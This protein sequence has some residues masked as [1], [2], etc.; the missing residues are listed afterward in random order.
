M[1]T[2]Q[3]ALI[4]RIQSQVSGFKTIGNP[5]VMAGLGQIGPLLPACLVV[6]GKA[7]P[8]VKAADALPAQ[9]E[10]AWDIVV[11]VAHQHTQAAHGLTESLAASLM[12]GVFK[13]VQ[14]WKASPNQ[15]KGFVYQGRSAPSYSMGYAEFPMTFTA[16]AVIGQ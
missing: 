9:E 15:R 2:L 5:S 11:I 4:A 10:Q 12:D 14:G 13:A 3:T 7:E 8:V 1:L 16:S 6:P